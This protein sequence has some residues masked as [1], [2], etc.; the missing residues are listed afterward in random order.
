MYLEFR[1]HS[2]IPLQLFITWCCGADRQ[3]VQDVSVLEHILLDWRIWHA[4]PKGVW[5]KVLWTLEQ[6][7]TRDSSVNKESF[8]K[9]EAIVKILLISKVRVYMCSAV[10]YIPL[11]QFFIANV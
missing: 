1:S 4:A 2:P 6:L 8:R 10:R 9:A 5:E 7:L 3:H 11:D